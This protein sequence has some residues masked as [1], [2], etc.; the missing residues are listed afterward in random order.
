MGVTRAYISRRTN[1]GGHAGRVAGQKRSIAESVE[2]VMIR[3]V[4]WTLAESSPNSEE[5]LD[6]YVQNGKRIRKE[7]GQR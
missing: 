6:E 2:D 1:R 7:K 5:V 4:A 3:R